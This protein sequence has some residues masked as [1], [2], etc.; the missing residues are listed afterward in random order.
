MELLTRVFFCFFESFSL[1]I[2]GAPSL[3]RGRVCHVSV[4]SLK[5]I[6]VSQYLQNIYI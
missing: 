3:T 6:V 1:V 2:F 4:L 5:S